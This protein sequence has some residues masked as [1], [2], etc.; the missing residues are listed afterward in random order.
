[1]IAVPD[2]WKQQRPELLLAI[3]LVDKDCIED[4][5]FD[6][7]KPADT[8]LVRDEKNDQP[9]MMDG[10]DRFAIEILKEGL[11]QIGQRELHFHQFHVVIH[12]KHVENLKSVSEDYLPLIKF[13]SKLAG[14]YECVLSDVINCFNFQ[15]LPEDTSKPK[16]FQLNYKLFGSPTDVEIPSEPDKG[17]IDE[18]ITIK[19]RT[20]LKLLKEYFMKKFVIPVEVLHGDTVIGKTMIY[21]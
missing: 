16:K 12:L 3:S 7:V 15:L 11:I 6:S 21:I 2:T 18:K 9:P 19:F 8:V 20:S 5:P 13:G 1:M 4:H 10:E 14:L 17:T